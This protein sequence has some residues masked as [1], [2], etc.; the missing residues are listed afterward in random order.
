M[1]TESITCRRVDFGK[2]EAVGDF[3]FRMDSDTIGTLY[4]WLPG[5]SGPDALRIQKGSAGGERVWGWDGDQD[6]PTTTPSI[7]AINEW[8]GY[9]RAGRLESC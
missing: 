7:H 4:I 6:K 8:H 2:I 9:L 3:C 5:T 1:N